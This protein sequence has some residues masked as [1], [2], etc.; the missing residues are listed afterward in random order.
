M[1]LAAE[2]VGTMPTLATATKASPSKVA[3]VFFSKLVIFN[4]PPFIIL[5]TYLIS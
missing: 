2:A 3:E 1:L 5:H 4:S